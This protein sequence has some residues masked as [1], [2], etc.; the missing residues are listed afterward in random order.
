M[1]KIDKKNKEI[2]RYDTKSLLITL[3][4]VLIFLYNLYYLLY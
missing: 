4:K 1:E 2:V 3:I